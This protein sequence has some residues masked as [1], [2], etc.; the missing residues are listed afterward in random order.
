[1]DK[2]RDIFW[3]KLPNATFIA[4]QMKAFGQIIKLHARVKKC[5]FGNFSETDRW[6]NWPCPVRAALKKPSVELKKYFSSIEPSKTP[7]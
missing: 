1:M 5:H 6:A 7:F 3:I 4:L 2:A